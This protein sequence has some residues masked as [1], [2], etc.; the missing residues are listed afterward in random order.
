M[1]LKRE[2]VTA[3]IVHHNKMKVQC[4]KLAARYLAQ[5]D[6]NEAARWA[7]AAKNHRFAGDSL[8]ELLGE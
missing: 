4:A 8:R 2:K 5:H 7:D 3:R 1:L 6:F